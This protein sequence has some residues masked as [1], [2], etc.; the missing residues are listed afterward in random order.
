MPGLEL[1]P[2]GIGKGYAV[3]RAVEILR[4]EHVSAALLSA[5]SSTIYAHG[6]PQGEAGWKVRVPALGHAESTL[7][8]VI[9]RDTSLS[10]ANCSEKYF[11][12]TVTCI[13]TS[14]TQGHS[15]P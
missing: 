6:A 3:E 11:V 9:L 5:G 8:T 14:W 1:D 7:S 13:A 15:G 2:G 12:K 4:S 10:T